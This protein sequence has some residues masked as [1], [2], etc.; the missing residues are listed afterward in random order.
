MLRGRLAGTSVHTAALLSLRVASQA[1]LLLFL[2]RLLD[3]SSYGSFATAASL[4]LV[5]GLFPTLGAGYLAMERTPRE[6]GAAADIWRYAWPMTVVLGLLL[7]AGY[8][9]LAQFAGGQAALS[10]TNLLWLGVAEL[11][12]APLTMLLSFIL[13]AHDRVPLSQWL[14]WAPLGMR[15]LAVL[16]CFLAPASERLELFVLLYAASSLAGFVL[17]WMIARRHVAL[18]WWPRRPS[19]EELRTGSAYA[20]MHA[21]AA[22]PTELDKVVASRVVG[23]YDTGLYAAASRILSA[24]VMPVMAMLLAAQPRLFQHA[25]APSREHASLVRHIAIISAGWGL[26]AGAALLMVSKLVPWLLGPSFAESALLLGW[27]AAAAPFLC[28][29]ISAGTI[30]VAASRPLQRTTIEL[31]GVIII[32]GMMVLL[33]PYVGVR[34][35][36]ITIIAAEFAMASAGWWM[37]ARVLRN[38]HAQPTDVPA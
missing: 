21:T 10:L 17:A 38:R 36:P 7:L 30:L 9:P 29:R 4:A 1:L 12:L 15:V 14:Q 13:R 11:L 18:G 31:S 27:L 8:I 33:T 26:F 35:L 3:P 28:L 23:A 25:R 5:L 34:G 37:I 2:V 16:P 32:V 22:C 24:S 19:L 20:L 6:E